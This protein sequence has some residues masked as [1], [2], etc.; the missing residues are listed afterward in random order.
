MAAAVEAMGG[1]SSAMRVVKRG[2]LPD[3]R[4]L[5]LH[6]MSKVSLA[7]YIGERAG[8]FA[9][10]TDAEA[11][12]KDYLDQ[13]PMV[14]KQAFLE[15]LPCACIASMQAKVVG[16]KLKGPCHIRAKNGTE[17]R[18]AL[19]LFWRLLFGPKLRS[20]HIT[21][22]S[23]ASSRS[24]QRTSSTS[25]N[26]N[27]GGGE[28]LQQLDADQPGLDI[29]FL[30]QLLAPADVFDIYGDVLEV[31]VREAGENA[32]CST[33]EVVLQCYEQNEAITMREK[34]FIFSLVEKFRNVSVLNLGYGC[35]DTILKEIA[36][37]CRF[38]TSLTVAGPR[39][40]NEGV[41]SLCGYLD[42]EPLEDEDGKESGS[43][44]E[45]SD[46][47]RTLNHLDIRL[48]LNVSAEG[49]KWVLRHCW[50]LERL[51]CHEDSLWKAL[52][53][54]TEFKSDDFTIPLVDLE[55]TQ[56]YGSAFPSVCRVFTRLEELSLWCFEPVTG[57]NSKY[58]SSFS[59]WTK[60]TLLTTLKL[61]NMNQPDITYLV[62]AL[63]QQLSH[64]YIDNFRLV[65]IKRHQFN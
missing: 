33:Q 17:F 8:A 34:G 65:R 22:L 16:E 15:I 39:V 3:P 11:D 21:N 55:L 38:V 64:V 47:C 24:L 4:I 45:A 30:K 19:T 13:L 31:I 61:F 46:I 23:A 29:D 10:Q 25:R 41:R 62:V 12:L 26:H 14:E 49:I 52:D 7:K 6:H 27:G 1:P 53:S 63:G 44:F 20:V 35:D 51:R 50:F 5:T 18:S 54:E 2:A 40:T 9:A 36:R 42:L 58:Y 56:N 57:Y 48:A 60:L 59:G 28:E 37:L 32:P 43:A